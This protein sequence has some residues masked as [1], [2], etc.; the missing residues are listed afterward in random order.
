LSDFSPAH[1]SPA[2]LQGLGEAAELIANFDWS[3]T[4]LGPLDAWPPSLTAI[5][6]FLLRSP[7]AARRASA[8]SRLR[9]ARLD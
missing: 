2:L 7:V 4:A 6:G 1:K 5:T 8:Y 9:M 3:V